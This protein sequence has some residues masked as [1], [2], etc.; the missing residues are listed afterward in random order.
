PPWRKVRPFRARRQN[1]STHK[2]PLP[3]SPKFDALAAWRAP[4]EQA[5][6]AWDP[7]PTGSAPD[8]QLRGLA[9]PL[10]SPLGSDRSAQRRHQKGAVVHHPTKSS[11][12]P[13]APAVPA[14]ALNRFVARNR[15][16]AIA[17]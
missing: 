16:F 4:E 11:P 5:W 14:T 9:L 12:H 1:P 15:D 7:T 10:G 8:R 6:P 2:P 17:L 3:P 13:T